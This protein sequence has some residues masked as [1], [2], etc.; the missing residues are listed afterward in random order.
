M[1]SRYPFDIFRVERRGVL[2]IESAPTVEAAKKLIEQFAARESSEYLV[3]NQLTGDR[4][5][6]ESPRAPAQ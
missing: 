4:V 6:L 5:M 1:N 2:W 3:L